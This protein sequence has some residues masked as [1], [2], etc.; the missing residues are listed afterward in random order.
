MFE[1]VSSPNVRPD[2]RLQSTSPRSGPPDIA[3]GATS[4]T[5]PQVLPADPSLDADLDVEFQETR[6]DRRRRIEWIKYYVQQR[7]LQKAFDLGW[8]GKPFRTSGEQRTAALAAAA[9]GPAESAPPAAST[10]ADQ[11]ALHRV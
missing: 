9:A 8:D 1:P 3:S 11:S 5:R 6:E 10:D 7:E 2:Q 4:Q